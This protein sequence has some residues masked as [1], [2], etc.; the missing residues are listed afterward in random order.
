MKVSIITAVY[1]RAESIGR[2]IESVLGQS[3]SNIEYII[4]DG[5]SNDGTM[6]IISNYRDRL[7]CILSE[8]DNGIYDALNKGIGQ[9]TGDI[10]G[11]LHSDDFFT[12]N[13]VVQGIVDGFLLDHACDLIYG[14]L[15]FFQ[16]ANPNKITRKYSSGFFRPWMMR[17]A[18]QPAHP[19]VYV[20]REFLQRVGLFNLTY[21]ISADFDWLFRAF[22]QHRPIYRYLQ[23]D[24]VRMQQGGASTDGIRALINHNK[25]D[26]AILKS[27]GVLSGWLFVFAKLIFKTVQIRI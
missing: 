2:T 20:G 16:V 14:D 18:L 3:Y 13:H 27:H 25:E 26:L 24:M 4:I 5:G 19:T 7:S 8:K 10:V 21:K 9:S 22:W 12:D 15:S 17:F 1:N 6:D 11:F 23:L